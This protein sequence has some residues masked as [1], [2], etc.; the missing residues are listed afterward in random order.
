MPISIF[1]K[2]KRLCPKTITNYNPQPSTV[3]VATSASITT[4]GTFQASFRIANESFT[5]AIILIE[6]MNQTIFG[7][8]FFEKHDILIHPKTRTQKLPSMTIQLT[9]RVHT[10]GKISSLTT[11]KNLFLNTVHPLSVKPNASE[12]FTCL[13]SSESFPEGP[14]AIVEPNPRFEKQ[15][16]LC[17]TSAIVKFD[18]KKQVSLGI[19]NL[20]PHQV[21]VQ[22]N[23]QVAKVT[24]LTAS[25]KQYL[26]PVNP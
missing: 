16:G 14:V 17:V 8:P 6:T 7:L 15:T 9:E 11:K 1:I 24:I 4:H 20:L 13:L 25:Q 19:L 18:A 23:A 5:E 2:S 21:T 12:I 3:E 22:K 26:Q 10:D